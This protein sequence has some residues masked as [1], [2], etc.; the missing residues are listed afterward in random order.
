MPFVERVRMV[1]TSA[2]PIS[3][4]VVRAT[5]AD[6]VPVIVTARTVV[7]IDDPRQWIAAETVQPAHLVEDAIARVVGESTLSELTARPLLCD[8]ARD[9]ATHRLAAAG[10]AVDDLLVE[11]V[12]LQLTADLLTWANRHGEETRAPHR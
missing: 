10:A 1:P 6:D 4:L 12:E 9:T 2:A 11:S 3:P 5:T 8:R 7:R